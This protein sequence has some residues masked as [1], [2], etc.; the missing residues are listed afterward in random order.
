M[1][2]LNFK[3]YQEQAATFASYNNI[4]YPYFALV[5]EVGEF[6][7]KIAKNMRGDRGAK[8]TQELMQKEVG[9]ILWNLSEICTLNGW[10]L[11]EIANQNIKKLTA[12]KVL[13]TIKG[14]G[15]EREQQVGN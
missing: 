5:E 11:E 1:S 2:E 15:D 8:E 9:D 10:S 12:R 4:N 13:G 3:S 6:C 7:G 14:D